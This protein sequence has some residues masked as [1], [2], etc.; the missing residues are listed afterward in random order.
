M[1]LRR[2]TRVAHVTSAH[3][4]LDVRIFEK[5]ARA[6]A[7][8][9]YDVHVVGQHTGPA[10]RQGV[11]IHALRSDSSRLWRMLAVPVRLLLRVRRLQPAICQLHD[12]ELIPIGVILKLMG[13]RVIYDAHE[14]LGLQVLNKG[15]IP[16]PIRRTASKFARFLERMAA[17]RFDAVVAAT[18]GVAANYPA[19]KVTVIFN[20]PRLADF[21]GHGLAHKDREPC[22]AYVG[23]VAETRGALEMAEAIDLLPAEANARLVVAGELQIGSETWE[24]IERQDRVEYQGVIDRVGVQRLL[25][26]ARLGLVVLHPVANYLESYPVKLFEYMAAG[27]PVVASDFPLWRSIITE[28]GCGLLVNPRDA[29]EIASAIGDL[30][31]DPARAEEMGRR[32][33]VAAEAAFSWDAEAGKLVDLYDRLARVATA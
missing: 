22:V 31:A 32:G 3:S 33:R 16:R 2:R 28:A 4:A 1:A 19:E 27:L 15:W 5:E 26:S 9:G 7:D 17:R 12:P 29:G 30:L 20:Y 6:L 23:A 10:T 11:E 25:G 24:R 13:F 18:P 14:D 8:A 21:V